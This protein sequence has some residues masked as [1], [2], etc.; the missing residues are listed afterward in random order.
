M[1]DPKF[2]AFGFKNLFLVCFTVFVVVR[3]IT[4]RYTM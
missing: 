3:S 2:L 1:N 4:I